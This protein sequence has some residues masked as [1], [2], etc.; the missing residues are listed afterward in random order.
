MN[1]MQ[2]QICYM[3]C[4]YFYFD[5][6]SSYPPADAHLSKIPTLRHQMNGIYE[7][8]KGLLLVFLSG[9]LETIQRIR[10][11]IFTHKG[12]NRFAQQSELC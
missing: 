1:T 3:L 12:S 9:C 5:V 6:L 10:I 7:A 11:E 2:I 4:Q 8:V